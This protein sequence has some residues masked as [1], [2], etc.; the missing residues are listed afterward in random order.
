MQVSHVLY[1]TI[2]TNFEQYLTGKDLMAMSQVDTTTRAGL[3]AQQFRDML[4]MLEQEH[5]IF[6]TNN[7]NIDERRE[8]NCFLFMVPIGSV[9][10]DFSFAFH[11]SPACMYKLITDYLFEH[12][13]ITLVTYNCIMMSF[14]KDQAF[15]DMITDFKKICFEAQ[16]HDIMEAD[17]FNQKLTHNYHPDYITYLGNNEFSTFYTFVNMIEQAC[18]RIRPDIVEYLF[19]HYED[20]EGTIFKY[21]DFYRYYGITAELRQEYIKWQPE[22]LT[23]L[24]KKY[25]PIV[26]EFPDDMFA[27]INSDE[28]DNQVLNQTVLYA[29]RCRDWVFFEKYVLTYQEMPVGYNELFNNIELRYVCYGQMIDTGYENLV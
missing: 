5:Q 1:N 10:R 23:W 17:E 2:G 26:G 13:R 9:F 11:V 20:E 22:D 21:H 18:I 24:H 29:L 4:S 15:K 6:I 3:L 27:L 7:W 16:D 12:G 14:G 25:D 8:L 28:K 19:S